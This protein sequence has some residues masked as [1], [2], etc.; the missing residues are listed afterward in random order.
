MFAH[1]QIAVQIFFV[2]APKRTQKIARGRPQTLAGAGMPLTDPIALIIA[3]PF[4][5][6]RTHGVVIALD[7]V[8]ALPL[9]RRTVV[10]FWV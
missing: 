1:R 9:V 4:L 2:D 6:A 7:S 8:V 10:S 3:C 5:L